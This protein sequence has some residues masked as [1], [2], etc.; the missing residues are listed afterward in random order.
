MKDVT[1]VYNICGDNARPI[2]RFRTLSLK[3]KRTQSNA[4]VMDSRLL[5]M[6]NMQKLLTFGN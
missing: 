2:L 5:L 4:N 3:S 6:L 1:A